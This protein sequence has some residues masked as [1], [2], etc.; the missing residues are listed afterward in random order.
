MAQ[1]VAKLAGSMIFK[2][3]MCQFDMTSEDEMGTGMVKKP[4][5]IMTNS[6][7]VER[8]VRRECGGNHRHVTLINGRA[9]ACQVYPEKFCEAACRGIA[10]QLQKDAQDLK[11]KGEEKEKSKGLMDRM[12]LATIGKM[13]GGM[14]SEEHKNIHED[15]ETGSWGPSDGHWIDYD[16]QYRDDI[17]G[18]PLE[19]SKVKA[20]REL[21]MEFFRKKGVY[22]KMPRSQVQ[23]KKVIKVRWVD[24]NKGDDKNPDYRSRLVAE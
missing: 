5:G 1:K 22:E 20:A 9:R 11:R 6:I 23:G 21:E 19:E 12:H 3:H 15:D 8:E 14:Q 24:V 4:T 18:L 17:T 16:T 10:R 7:E 13:I 2:T